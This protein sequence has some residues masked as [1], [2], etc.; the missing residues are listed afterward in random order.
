MG[1]RGLDILKIT[2][3]VYL[4]SRLIQAKICLWG[5]FV[6]FTESL[7]TWKILAYYEEAKDSH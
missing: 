7:H 4:V 2:A 3:I 6:C 1:S 5:W